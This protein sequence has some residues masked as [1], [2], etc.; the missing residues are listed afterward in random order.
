MLTDVGIK[1]FESAPDIDD[2]TMNDDSENG[3]DMAADEAAAYLLR[4]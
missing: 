4:D 2:I 3:D 1:I